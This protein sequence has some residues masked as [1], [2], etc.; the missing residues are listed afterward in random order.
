[1]LLD[2]AGVYSPASFAAAFLGEDGDRVI[3]WFASFFYFAEFLNP[4]L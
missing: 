4:N 3:L 1:M 2:P